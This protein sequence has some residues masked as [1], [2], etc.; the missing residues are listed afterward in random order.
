MIEPASLERQTMGNPLLYL[1]GYQRQNRQLAIGNCT[2]CHLSHCCDFAK[3]NA[4]IA[5]K[6]FL[7][8]LASLDFKLSVGESVSEWL[9]FFLQLAHLQVFQIFFKG[10]QNC[11]TCAKQFPW[12]PFNSSFFLLCQTTNWPWC[13]AR[14]VEHLKFEW[15]KIKQVT[16]LHPS[17]LV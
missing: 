1:N 8:A 5:N 13:M 12:V 17:H 3:S 6:I 14:Q 15:S 10:M 2:N 11:S 9:I 4:S 7:D 16:I